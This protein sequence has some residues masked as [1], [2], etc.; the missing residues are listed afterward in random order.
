MRTGASASF[1][2][3]TLVLSFWQ[4]FM[5]FILNDVNPVIICDLNGV[6]VKEF[7]GFGVSEALGFG[8]DQAADN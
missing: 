8:E 3:D 4:C 5:S 7:L 6:V 2:S 1:V